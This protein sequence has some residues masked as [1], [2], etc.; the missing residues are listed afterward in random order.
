MLVPRVRCAVAVGA[1]AV[2]ALIAAPAAQAHPE[3]CASGAATWL[4]V[5]PFSEEDF[6]M[7]EAD[8]VCTPPSVQ[9]AYDDSGALLAPNEV[10]GS[11]NLVH[12]ANIPK[13]GP[14]VGTSNL[15]SDIAFWGKYAY[16]GNYN[17]IQIT[18]ISDPENPTVVSQIHCPGSQN[19]V[20]VWKGLLITSTDSSRNKAE[21]EGNT[22]QPA[23]NPA[24]WEGIR[25]FDVSDP[26]NPS[27]VTAVET[28]CGSHTH[29]IIPEDDRLVVYV[30]SYDVSATAAQCKPP[31]DKISIVEVPLDQPEDSRLLSAPLLFPN[32][33]YDGSNGY[34]RE[35]RGCHDITV[36][37]AIGLAAGACMGEG[38]LMD[39]SDPENPVVVDSVFDANFAFWHSA[40][41]SHDGKKVLFTDEKGGGSGAECNPTVGPTR[42]A[43]A[44]Y[45][46]GPDKRMTFRSYFKIP[47][48]QENTEN[49]VAHNG[50]LLP[51]TDRDILVQAWYQGGMSVVDWTD[52]DNP[53]ELAWW[54]RGPHVPTALA[55][56][57][58][59][60]WYNG[61]IYGNEIQRGLDV[62]QLT[63]PARAG[64]GGKVPYLNAQVQEPLTR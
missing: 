24:S 5:V 34:T 62:F 60:Y 4:G 59:T 54:D 3:E 18:D 28:D 46:I 31:H 53:Q 50:N 36:Y 30:S 1:C 61:K 26:A 37:P 49:C 13:T 7:H 21:C 17:G 11:G 55:G 45:T 6:A 63:G 41:F 2:A 56:F 19:D 10:A 14:F 12:L 57:W 22:T 8:G 47:R 38:V 40:T 58:S 51:R 23:S 20:S 15:N 9:A 16:Q 29:T 25:V 42:G 64:T 43:D 52:P 32:G 35:T 44:I 39:I 33:G 48:T 27:Y